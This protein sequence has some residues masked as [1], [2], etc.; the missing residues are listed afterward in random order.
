ML[1][2][3][4][5]PPWSDANDWLYEQY[6]STIQAA[7]VD[8]DGQA[9]LLARGP[10]GMETWRFNSGT[11]TWEE[12]VKGTPAWSD[13]WGWDYHKYYSTIQAADV[14]GDGQAELL[15][16]GAT[17]METFHFNADTAAGAR[18]SG[19]DGSLAFQFTGRQYS[20][21]QADGTRL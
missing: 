13:A 11:D 20:A 4:G 16:R 6:Y 10:A 9:E 8:G 17:G 5:N 21:R 14:D 19:G 15:A 12:V 7:D 1:T 2:L 18:P 3:K